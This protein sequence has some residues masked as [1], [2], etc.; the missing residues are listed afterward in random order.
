MPDDAE[1]LRSYTETRSNHAFTELVGRH[2]SLVYFTA[3]RGTAG[4]S[5]LAQDVAQAVF[6]AA[7][8][9][10]GSLQKHPSISGWLYATTRHM[11][12]RAARGEQ[13][14]RRIERE[15]AV[16]NDMTKAE[17]GPEWERLRPVI[18][19]ALEDLDGRDREAILV[20]FFQGRP[21]AEIGAAW[22]VTPDAARMRVDRALG[23]LGQTLRRR[24]IDSLPAALGMALAT[25]S[26]LALPAAYVGAVSS[27]ALA[28][29]AGL[30]VVGALTAFMS[31]K[32]TIA[33]AGIVA[34]LA[35][36]TAIF[37]HGRAADAE[38]QRAAAVQEHHEVQVRLT[39]AEQARAAAESRAVDAER[40][41]GSLL[42]AVQAA[43]AKPEPEPKVQ[44]PARKV[45]VPGDPLGRSLEAVFTDGIVAVLGDR[46]VTVADVRREVEPLLPKVMAE[47]TDPDELTH[48]LYALQNAAV[49]DIVGRILYLKE[50]NGPLPN[51]GRRNI[52]PA[53]IE[54]EVGDRMNRAYA[55]DQARF[56]A[57]LHA[58][59]QDAAA[60]R[61]QVEEDIIYGYMRNQA[62][63]LDKKAK[64]KAAAAK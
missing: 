43:G 11:A 17:A 41:S 19:A 58:T 55:G 12:A 45:P 39:Q 20:R 26:T 14:R 60:Y 44:P 22:R 62:R 21:F 49:A 28:A 38:A 47:T 57:H 25:Q 32:F 27:A 35:T 24:G 23:K 36:G 7:A 63:N 42:A 1:L 52:D 50:F 18:D 51:E 4:D 54:A 53:I 2:L 56:E 33:G 5:A 61:K 34:V 40:D 10:A 16:H 59:G 3:L 31:T 46:T 9:K 30:T 48:R 64:A 29:G 13:T 15:A 37:E 6:T 8:R